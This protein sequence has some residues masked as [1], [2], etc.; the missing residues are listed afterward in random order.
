MDSRVTALSRFVPTVGAAYAF[1]LAF[2]LFVLAFIMSTVGPW[3]AAVLL[4]L[5]GLFLTLAAVV[6]ARRGNWII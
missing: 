2:M 3:W 6:N 5:G 4:V 1:F